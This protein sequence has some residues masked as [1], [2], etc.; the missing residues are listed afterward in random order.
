VQLSVD[1]VDDLVV[2]VRMGRDLETGLEVYLEELELAGPALVQAHR[3]VGNLRRGQLLLERVGV[4]VAGPH[5]VRGV[6]IEERIAAISSEF[7]IRR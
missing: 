2:G 6:G 3:R 1:D 4:D 7:T 5:E